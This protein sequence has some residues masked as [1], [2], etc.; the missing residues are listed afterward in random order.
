[1]ATEAI[2][3]LLWVLSFLLTAPGP[4]G[5]PHEAGAQPE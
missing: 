5:E 3:L 2:M 4:S 1:V